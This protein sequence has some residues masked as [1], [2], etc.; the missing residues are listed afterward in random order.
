MS[1]KCSGAL[2]Y[3]LDTKRFLFLFRKQSKNNNVW[4]LAGGTNEITEA[5][6]PALYREIY[7]EVGNIDVIKTF[8]LETF[9]STDKSLTT[10][11][12]YVQLKKNLYL[13]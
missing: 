12:I 6:G 9:V 2:I 3:A 4:G 5:P 7:E 10:L 1:I 11:R 13:R 8:P